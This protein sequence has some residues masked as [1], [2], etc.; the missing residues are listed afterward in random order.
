[1]HAGKRWNDS[2]S[3][4]SIS[5]SPASNSLSNLN[6]TR[7]PKAKPS[8]VIL[9]NCA[10]RYSNWNNSVEK[11]LMK[12]RNSLNTSAHC[13]RKTS[14]WTYCSPS[15]KPYWGNTIP[16][17]HALICSCR[18]CA[19]TGNN[20]IPMFVS[21]ATAPS[22]SIHRVKKTF[23]L[24]KMKCPA[25]ANFVMVWPRIRNPYAKQESK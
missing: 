22:I 17:W 10:T 5:S 11:P 20:L 2:S 25:F 9:R 12:R 8:I 1:M 18:Q 21:S 6:G 14:V 4:N 15:V 24:G 19:I 16:I 13:I 3:A 23:V 7:L